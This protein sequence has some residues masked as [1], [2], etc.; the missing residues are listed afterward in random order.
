[1]SGRP[2]SGSVALPSETKQERWWLAGPDS[3]DG[4]WTE[5]ILSLLR[6][7]AASTTTTRLRWWLHPAFTVGGA[8]S[9]VGAA[10][11]LVA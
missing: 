6:G 9:L 10:R 11:P 4:V 8:A 5:D 3:F 2:V 1:M 7:E